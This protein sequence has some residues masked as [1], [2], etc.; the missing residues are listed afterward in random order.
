MSSKERQNNFVMITK[1]SFY[2]ASLMKTSWSFSTRDISRCIKSSFKASPDIT[3]S[4][5]NPELVVDL[6]LILSDNI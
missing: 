3:S 2:D 4:K 1:R 6:S 5:V